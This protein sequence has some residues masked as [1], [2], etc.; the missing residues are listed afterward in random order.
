[1]EA[2]TNTSIGLGIAMTMNATVTPIIL[3]H[4]VPIFENLVLSGIFTI[5]S[6]A[7][8]YILRRAFNGRSVW[9]AIKDRYAY[10]FRPVRCKTPDR[11]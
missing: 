5:V 11:S 10:S 9:Q 1:M 6:I 7:R 2:L 8:S 3:N 4:P